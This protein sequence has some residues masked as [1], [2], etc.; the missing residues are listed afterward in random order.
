MGFDFR[1]FDY[2]R[3][4]V[5][6]GLRLVKLLPAFTPSVNLQPKVEVMLLHCLMRCNFAAVSLIFIDLEWRQPIHVPI[7]D[8]LCLLEYLLILSGFFLRVLV[9]KNYCT[10]KCIEIPL[11]SWSSRLDFV[12]VSGLV[13]D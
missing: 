1:V 8:F 10:L 13:V 12:L 7:L 9:A 4:A 6:L 2:L 5:L 11:D 3:N